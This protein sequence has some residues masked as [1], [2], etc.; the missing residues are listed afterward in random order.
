MKLRVDKACGKEY[1]F[2]LIICGLNISSAVTN[3][4]RNH[5]EMTYAT[6]MAIVCSLKAERKE[7][8]TKGFTIII[9]GVKINWKTVS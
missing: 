6:I 7:K 8:E 9:L 5:K 1:L 3:K 4:L 2:G